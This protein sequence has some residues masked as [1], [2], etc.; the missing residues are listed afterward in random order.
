MI[1]EHSHSYDDH[2]GTQLNELAWGCKAYQNVNH[3]YRYVPHTANWA[4]SYVLWECVDY[5]ADNLHLLDVLST[6]IKQGCGAHFECASEH[7]QRG[8]VRVF[9][10]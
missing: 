5:V 6:A 7:F 4:S 8:E 3:E 10:R 9:A 1:V 2:P